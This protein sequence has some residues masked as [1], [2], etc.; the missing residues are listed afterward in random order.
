[1]YIMSE[2][3]RDGEDRITPEIKDHLAQAISGIK[4]LS[5]DFRRGLHFGV[6]VQY[7]ARGGSIL[8]QII[9]RMEPEAPEESDLFYAGAVLGSIAMKNGVDPAPLEEG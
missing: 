2:L 4:P 9:M 5:R 3:P 1:M 8:D 7:D 6:G